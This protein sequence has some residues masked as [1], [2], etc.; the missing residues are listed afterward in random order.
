MA[1]LVISGRG[2]R[3]NLGRSGMV[4]LPFCRIGKREGD[5]S[6]DDIEILGDIVGICRLSVST[7]YKLMERTR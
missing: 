2:G 7:R 3:L 6:G 4:R 5:E 1:G